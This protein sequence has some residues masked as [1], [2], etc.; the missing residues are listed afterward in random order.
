VAPPAS[1][2]VADPEAAPLTA[3]LTAVPQHH[4]HRRHAAFTW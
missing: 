1:P 3:T 4:R 2:A